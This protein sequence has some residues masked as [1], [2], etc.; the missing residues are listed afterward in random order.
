MWQV[1]KLRQLDISSNTLS[2]VSTDV[3]IDDQHSLPL[4]ALTTTLSRLSQLESLD[5]STTRLGY[6]GVQQL[7]S[8]HIH[9]LHALATA[10]CTLQR[11]V[12]D[13]NEL[14]DDGAI[15]VIEMLK[16]SSSLTITI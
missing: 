5:L 11:L 8:L 3:A 15:V 13:S 10:A 7:S 1:Q 16:T 12:L 4:F 14:H 2:V 9:G 6:R